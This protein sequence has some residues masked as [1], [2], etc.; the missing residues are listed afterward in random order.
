MCGITGIYSFDK[1]RPIDPDLLNKM[2]DSLS[3]RGPDDRGI[4]I[5]NNIGLGFRR[6]SILDLSPAGHQPMSNEDNSIWIVFNGEIYNYKELRKILLSKGHKFKS[7][8]DTETIIHAYEEYGVNCLEYLDG[9]FAFAIW[10]SNLKQIFAA[11]DR[12]GIKPFHFY[13]DDVFFAFGSE[14]KALLKIP[15]IYSNKE[16]DY[17]AMW[18]Y[19]SLMQVP[20]PLTIYKNIKKLEPSHALLIDTN[21]KLRKWKYWNLKIEQDYSK[22]EQEYQYELYNLFENSI[23]NHLQS[24]VPVGVFLSGGFDSSSVA[25]FAAKVSEKPINTFSVSFK[26]YNGF[27]ESEYQNLVANKIGSIHNTYFA[28]SVIL[29]AAEDIIRECDEPFAISSAIPLYY[30]AKLASEKVK[31]V[32]SGDGSDEVF[33]GYEW[34]YSYANKLKNLNYVPS[35]LAKLIINILDNDKTD[36]KLKNS[37]VKKIIKYSNLSLQNQE[38][39]YLSLI[40]VFND[41]QKTSILKSEIVDEIRSNLNFSYLDNFMNAPKDTLNQMLYFDIKTSLH[42]EMLTKIDRVT[43]LVS[44]EGRVPFLDKN[45]VETALK[46]PGKFKLYNGVGKTILKNSFKSV[47]PKE[48]LSRKK[49]GFSVPLKNWLKNITTDD[50]GHLNEIIN[51]EQLNRY[52]YCNNKNIYDYTMHL[53]VLKNLD[54]WLDKVF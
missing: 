41:F 6:L 28:E 30:I 25:S 50:F 17:L 21:G 48:I 40:T 31:V 42:D 52:I 24:D 5:D 10:D 2:T 35:S 4:F 29:Q 36:L 44:I 38:N 8:T 32:L 47:L 13:Y 54:I 23:K 27:D 12:F 39:R 19:L 18:H 53:W 51:K 37:F 49:E 46:I 3:H 11:R 34:R 14:I 7:N 16:I 33:A 45:F 26:G 43:S 1:T 22:S 20:T 15:N 9:M